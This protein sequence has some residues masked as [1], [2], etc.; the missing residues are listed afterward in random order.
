MEE[1]RLKE[2]NI[3]AGELLVGRTISR[4]SYWREGRELFIEFADGWRL[5]VNA[6]D[7]LELSILEGG[8]G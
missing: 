2:L 5:Y 3:R 8:G 7:D 6:N 4:V 1:G